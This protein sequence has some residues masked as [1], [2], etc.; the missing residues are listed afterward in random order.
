[1]KKIYYRF[2]VFA[3]GLYALL[4]FWVFSRFTVDDAFISWRYGKN[5]IDF[6]V[7]NYNPSYF[8]L[9]QAYTNPIYA[10]LSVV[11]SYFGFD[12][13]LFFKG[14]SVFTI[15]L[16][17]VYFSRKTN[18]SWLMLIMFVGLPATVVHAFGGLET[19]LFVSLFAALMIALYENKVTLSIILSLVLFLTRPESWLLVIIV[20][21]YFFIVENRLLTSFDSR[22]VS[23]YIRSLSFSWLTG[24]RAFFA[25][26]FPL[27]GYFLFHYWCFGSALPNTFYVKA[28]AGFDP[29][30]FVALI[31]FIAPLSIL[32]VLG[33]V[34][35]FF[36]MSAFF[37][38][39][40]ISYSTS[41]LQMNYSSRFAFH[42]FSPVFIFLIYLS[43]KEGGEALYVSR[44]VDFSKVFSVKQ[45]TAGKFF[46]V[47]FFFY[48]AA[49][50]SGNKVEL[51]QLANYYPRTLDAHA[52]LGKV[53]G[54][55]SS[56][57]NI[58][59]F[60]LGDAGMAAY[61]SG[62]N[63]LDNVGLG[64]SAVARHGLD[65][66][67]LNEYDL[68]LVVFYAGPAGINFDIYNQKKIFEWSSEHGFKEECDVYWRGDYF[69]RIYSKK[70]IPEISYL[71]AVSAEKNNL[72]E[73]EYVS[74]NI[75]NAPWTYWHE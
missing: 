57:Y 38:A 8:D 33:R 46:L 32:L 59:A 68:D 30:L 17:F 31:F 12:I 44:N 29:F 45:E 37:F 66:K 5:F 24:G 61:Y 36:A 25:M 64:S 70:N 35:L 27:F 67:L 56:K 11:G 71:C 62:V 52:E 23:E 21:M 2:A 20:P 58:R 55:V 43:A 72:S 69:L 74:R 60:S 34:K 63:A 19:F 75:R 16:F 4:M 51:A 1:M 54:R 14:F 73:K 7:W 18:G 49:F 53:I 41:N 6:G 28:G 9:T 48:F 15:V 40:A 22:G 50:S 10:A 13:V 42:I 3:M 65:E 47:A 39:M 26:F